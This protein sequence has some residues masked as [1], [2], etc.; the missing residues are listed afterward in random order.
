MLGFWT[1]KMAWRLGRGRRR[2]LLLY[3]SSMALGVAA[4]VALQGFGTN[5]TRAVGEEA[6]ALLGAD[7]Q[8]E[9]GQP[10][11][12]STQALV[13]SLA[14]LPG[15]HKARRL[16]FPSMATFPSAGRGG[17]TRLASIRAVEKGY[18]FYGSLT[19]D[20]PKA[21]GRF[22]EGGGALVD[23][24]LLQQFGAQPGDSVRIGARTYAIAGKLQQSPGATATSSMVSPRVFVPYGTV[25]TTL[26]ARGSRVEYETYVKLPG[27][28]D[29][30]LLAGELRVR[31]EGN[32]VQV[33]T[34]SSVAGDWQAGVQNLYRFLG[35]VGFAALLLGGLGVASA[36]NVYVKKEIETVAVLR[37]LGAKGGRAFRVFLAQA[38]GLGAAAAALGAALGVGVQLLL[39]D[40][41]GGFLPVSTDF[42]VSW[43]AVGGGLAV[44]TGAALLF[45]LL[46]L[47]QVRGVSPMRALR[48]DVADGEEARANRGLRG[49][50]WA[51][52]AAGTAGFSVQLAPDWR[53][54]LGYAGGV[55]AVFALLALLAAGIVRAARAFE[56]PA[57][58]YAWRQGLANLHRPGNQTRLLVGVLGFG[59]FL[60]LT[61]LLAGRTLREQLQVADQAGRPNIVLFDV[62]PDQV[63]GVAQ[64]VRK[65]D[66]PVL[67]TVPIVPMQLDSVKGR[68]IEEIKAAGDDEWAHAH[69]FRATYR[70][71]LIDS[72]R[73]TAGAF[74]RQKRDYGPGDVVPISVEQDIAG[75]LD[76]GLGDTLTFDVQGVP[77]TAR[78]ASL[79]KVDWQRVQTNFFMVFPPG[80]LAEAP[81][82]YAVLSR[83]GS[84]A[85]SAGLQQA[86]ARQFPNVLAIDLSLVLEVFNRLFGRLAQVMRFMALFS[87]LT[88]LV[89]LAGAVSASRYQRAEESVLLKTLGGRRRQVFQIMLAEHLLLGLLAA[90]AGLVLSVGAAW[91]LAYFV[92]E[93][94]LALAPRAMALVGA[95]VP[96]LTAGIGLW[97]SRGLYARPPM[98]VLRVE[99]G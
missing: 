95:A 61:L 45:A 37:C 34:P 28:T 42:E 3:L 13:D 62:Q 85:A 20:P 59:T 53:L 80:A 25:D 27:G 2:R 65:Q 67:D 5:L 87:V 6:K 21:A 1:I 86:V 16:S 57:L 18:P 24:A 71:H 99:A 26:L 17:G 84:E 35:L 8:F 32:E 12:D 7:L 56:L 76:V 74:V 83:A 41:L 94:P 73:I 96:A 22:R 98:E 47:L 39:P 66:L 93:A 97:N 31:L 52:I 46:P 49:G 75:D 90:L 78:A 19:T 15:A 89:V 33:R 69:D 48:A 44:G 77:I 43:P 23:G 38:A 55:V 82:T 50:V 88:G 29:L 64:T 70:D 92:F 58:P 72:E 9:R 14:G 30:P 36:M 68:S 60:I 63:E 81:Q 79:R 10:F 11:S 91:A 54:G 51:L 4:L 40:L